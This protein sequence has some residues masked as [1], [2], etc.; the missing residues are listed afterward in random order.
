MIRS[1]QFDA[2]ENILQQALGRV[3][4]KIA[5]AARV[6]TLDSV[7]ISGWEQIHAECGRLIAAR[8][9]IGAIGLNL[10]NYNDGLTDVW[11]DK[12][13]AIEFT[14]YGNDA[15]DFS[16][17]SIEEVRRVSAKPPTPWQGRSRRRTVHRVN[18][19][20]LESL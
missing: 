3:R 16:S 14:V 1:G 18:R 6:S 11:H 5:D 17:A 8:L 13:P 19:H 7:R 15:V 9:P 4:T 10:S 2:A 20:A 12:E